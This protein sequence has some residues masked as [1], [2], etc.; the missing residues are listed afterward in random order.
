MC[1]FVSKRVITNKCF[2]I[3]Y[4]ASLRLALDVLVAR[5]SAYCP[6]QRFVVGGSSLLWQYGSKFG[7]RACMEY[8]RLCASVCSYYYLPPN[9]YIIL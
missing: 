8:D 2:C 7:E 1:L 3:Q 9:R 5:A 4:E 6:E